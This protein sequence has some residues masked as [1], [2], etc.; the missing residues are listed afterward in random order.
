MSSPHKKNNNSTLS[1]HALEALRAFEAER[2]EHQAKF[3]K[4]QAEA[5]SNNSLLSIDTFAEDWNESQFWYSDETANTL[6][7]E[8]LRDATSDMTIG[9]VSAPSVFVALKNILVSSTIITTLI[10]S[11]TIAISSVHWSLSA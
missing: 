3:Q 2:E 4:L 6:A 1:S 11:I 10:L 9:V 8:L 7:T 5:E